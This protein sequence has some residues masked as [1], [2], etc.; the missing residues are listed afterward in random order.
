MIKNI[1]IICAGLFFASCSSFDLPVMEKKAGENFDKSSPE[2]VCMGSEKKEACLENMKLVKESRKRKHPDPC[3][4]KEQKRE[5]QEL[6]RDLSEQ[7]I[8]QG[9]VVV[10]N[11][12]VK[13]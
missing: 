1:T 5:I 8:K 12:C 13:D 11:D 2:Q 4:L 6:K 7:C 9:G 10:G 3:R